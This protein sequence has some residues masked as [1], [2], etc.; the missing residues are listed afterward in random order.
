LYWP[1]SLNSR[2]AA[3][4]P[5]H[6]GT[7]QY[8][9]NNNSTA[10]KSSRINKISN[11]ELDLPLVSS[12]PPGWTNSGA[13]G[14]VAQDIVCNTTLA[15][16]PTDRCIFMRI[17]HA[18][19]AGTAIIPSVTPV[20]RFFNQSITINKLR[21]ISFWIRYTGPVDTTR[22]LAHCQIKIGAVEYNTPTVAPFIGTTW[23]KVE[24]MPTT[25]GVQTLQFGLVSVSSAN[26]TTTARGCEFDGFRAEGK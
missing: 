12:V 7:Y 24:I 23:Q 1:N 25:L 18:P 9:I 21:P 15:A 17:I 13:F 16:T 5:T 22:R 20:D 14:T 4:T 19:L 8:Q 10:S 3:N 2:D 11:A 26:T 6:T